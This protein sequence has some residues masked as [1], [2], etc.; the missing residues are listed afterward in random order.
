M[1]Q[2]ND[3]SKFSL[4]TI[5]GVDGNVRPHI[6][7]FSTRQVAISNLGDPDWIAFNKLLPVPLDPGILV[8]AGFICEPGDPEGLY[9]IPLH[10]KTHLSINHFTGHAAIYDDS[11]AGN[12]IPLKN[13]VKFLHQLQNLYFALTGQEL[14]IRDLT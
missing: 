1:I 14:D 3:L 8:K 2:P 6:I 5:D 10:L 4:F 11:L 13:R 9:M 12:Y 7:N